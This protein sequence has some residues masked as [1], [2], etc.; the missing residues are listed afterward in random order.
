MIQREFMKKSPEE[1]ERLMKI[2]Q[3]GSSENN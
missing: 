2:L 1:Q 3:E